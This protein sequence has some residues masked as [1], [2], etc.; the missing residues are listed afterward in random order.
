MKRLIER[1]ERIGPSGLPVYI[2]GESGTGKELV[3]RALHRCGPGLDAPFVA[4]NCGGIPSGLFE[5]TFFG[6]AKGAFT[7]A[8]HAR[9]GLFQRASGGTLL[10]DEVGELPLEGQTKLLRAL[11]SGEVWPVGADFAVPVDVRILCAT[12]RDLGR[13]VQEGGFR[14][15]L[16]FRL[17]VVRIN[18]PPLRDRGEDIPLIVA[19]VLH[20]LQDSGAPEVSLD[21]GVMEALK[22]HAWPG[23][24]RQ[25]Q[26]IVTRAA[27]LCDDRVVTL[28]DLSL[29]QPAGPGADSVR[30]FNGLDLHTGSLKD[31]VARLETFV[32]SRSLD[33]HDRNKSRVARDLGLSRAGLNMKLKR[34]GLWEE[35]E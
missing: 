20:E 9:E 14:E 19:K 10:L 16:F 27:L 25:L 17:N 5:S 2:Y 12:H 32:L 34:L 18:V 29:G 3:A 30:G 13:R 24:V 4:Q 11:E 33:R 26:S 22:S 1:I 15:D 6:H 23:N 7:D 8:K 28:D 35:K 21:A 31:R